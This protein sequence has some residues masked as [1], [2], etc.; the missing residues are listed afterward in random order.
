[1]EQPQLTVSVRHIV[2][3]DNPRRYF[4]PTKMA[5]FERTVRA[6]G[7]LQPIL[8]R[9]GANGIFKIVA[10]E[11]RFRVYKAI[12]GDDSKIPAYVREMTDEEAA[13]AALSE[14]VD[15]DNMT[16]VEEAESAARVLGDCKGNREEAAARLGWSTTTLDKRLSLM[17]ATDKVRTALQDKRILLG[18][19]ELLAVCRKDAQDNAIDLLLKQDKLMSVGEFKAYIDNA[20]LLLENAIFVKTDCAGCIHNSGNQ[21]ALFSEVISGGRCTNKTCYEGKTEQ[22]L[23]NRQTALKDEFQQVRIA[24]A[25]EN[26]T[27]IPLVAEGLK[28][29]GVEQAKACQI[30]QNFGAVISA[31]PDK[32]GL[33]YKNVCMDVPCNVRMV[34][35]RVKAQKAAEVEPKPVSTPVPAPKGSEDKAGTN[36]PA[37]LLKMAASSPEK[38]TYPEPSNRIKE[39]REG[40]WRLIFTRL[41]SKLSVQDNRAVLLALCAT[42]PGIIDASAIRAAIEPVVKVETMSSPGK[43]LAELLNLGAPQLGGALQHIAANVTAGPTGLELKEVTSILQ[44]F[45]AK[46]ADYWA[47]SNGFFELL[48]KNEIDAVCEEL[49]IKTA[50]GS[51]YAKAR[52]HGKEDYIK[53]IL[54][55]AGFEYRNRIPKLMTW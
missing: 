20:A 52:A 28:G 3:G 21:G 17:Y 7:L 11:R 55:I 49:G 15:R 30:C 45:E 22:E 38:V 29:V 16:P 54:G 42:R 35:E 43:V 10:G 19:A 2:A 18:H 48:T 53:A 25:G 14:N 37:K 44:T 34:S 39:Y 46:V 50:M 4:D 47:V 13:A 6:Q 33:T 26:F 12:Y 51:E 24:R 41:V 36:D 1:M 9:P 8:L 40:V 5:E 27:I 32:L 23:V 31:V